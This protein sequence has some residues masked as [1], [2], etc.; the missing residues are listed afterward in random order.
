MLEECLYDM[1]YDE[2][3]AAWAAIKVSDIKPV[4]DLAKRLMLDQ[5]EL[6]GSHPKAVYG[7]S[8]HMVECMLNSVD[9]VRVSRWVHG[10]P[11][12]MDV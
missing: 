1:E 8:L 3:I 6:C 9:W 2:S 5:P 10:D 11:D 4:R 7:R 12:P